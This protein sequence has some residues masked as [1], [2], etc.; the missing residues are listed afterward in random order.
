MS[1]RDRDEELRLRREALWTELRELRAQQRELPLLDATEDALSRRL[2]SFDVRPDPEAPLLLRVRIASPCDQAWSDMAGD[3]RSRFC[4]RCQ[5]RVYDL[6]AMTRKEAEALL[7]SGRGTCVRFYRRTDGTVMTSDCPVRTRRRLKV[8]GAISALGL[9]AAGGAFAAVEPPLGGIA[10]D[11]VDP[12]SSFG[13]AEDL[14]P[15]S[16]EPPALTLGARTRSPAPP[17][18]APESVRR[19]ATPT[20]RR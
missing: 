5:K 19:A 2:E 10:F 16:I 6:A 18:L 11:D 14:D 7:A 13:V 8:A 15:P 12:A 1:Y 17:V 20:G 9:L 3:D 4:F